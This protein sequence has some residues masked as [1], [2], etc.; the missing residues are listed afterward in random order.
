ML[1]HRDDHGTVSLHA[2]MIENL[3]QI[4]RARLLY[5][6]YEVALAGWFWKLLYACPSLFRLSEIYQSSNTKLTK[7]GYYNSS[8]SPH[9]KVVIMR[10]F[11]CR[12]EKASYFD[13]R[14]FP[15][16]LRLF[17]YCVISWGDSW[18]FL[19]SYE[20]LT[21]SPLLMPEKSWT[22]CSPFLKS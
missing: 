9:A 6:K 17:V 13:C 10:V 7:K 8:A 5:L 16:N 18:S 1:H 14:G 12:V 3:Y 11:F 15:C 22:R 19:C 20:F 2:W 4:H 21:W